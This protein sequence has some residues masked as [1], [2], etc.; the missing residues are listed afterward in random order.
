MGL[1]T[2]VKKRLFGKAEATEMPGLRTDGVAGKYAMKPSLWAVPVIP[3][4]EPI[5][6]S[7]D[8]HRKVENS[9]D[10]NSELAEQWFESGLQ[11]AMQGD[12]LGSIQDWEKAIE[13]KPHFYYAW[14]NRGTSLRAL[15]RYEE[16]IVS[17]DKAIKLKPDLHETWNNCGVA[18][19]S[20]GRKEEAIV[21]FDR[22]RVR[23]RIKN[24]SNLLS[25]VLNFF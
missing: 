14:S 7:S 4:V 9:L 25:V 23:I 17:F 24:F 11:K 12:M 16:A 10:R 19:A 6:L 8:A 1:R 20:L 13:L 18:L 22:A 21:S 2:W 15:D 3:V 5:A